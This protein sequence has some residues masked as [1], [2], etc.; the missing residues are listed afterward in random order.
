MAIE[1]NRDVCAHCGT[2]LTDMSTVVEDDGT[3]YC[4]GNCLIHAT[5]PELAMN[6]THAPVCRHCNMA[7]VDTSTLVQRG[8][9]T[10]CCNNCANAMEEIG[11]PV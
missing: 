3:L 1:L 9:N 11:E 8:A 7:I 6:A 2:R 5:K 4:C 10:Y